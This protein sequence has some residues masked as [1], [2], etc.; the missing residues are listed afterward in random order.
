MQYEKI[1]VVTRK[2]RLDELIER[3]N[4]LNQA[5]FYIEHSGGNFK[6]Y[7]DEHNAYYRSLDHVHRSIDI[8]L[9]FQFMDRYLLST[10][11]IT[12]KDVVVSVGQD[13]LAANTAKYIGSQPL[14]AI[15]PDPS[16]IDGILC[17]I[18]I[19]NWHNVLLR[20]LNNKSKIKK[21]TLAKI[22]LNDTQSLIAFNDFFIGVKSHVSSRYTIEFGD[23]KERQSSSGIIVSTGAGSTGWLSSVFNMGAAISK[24]GDGHIENKLKFAW[25]EKRLI[26][27]VR[28][29]FLSRYSSI[30]L[31]AGLIDEKSSLKIE[32]H[33]AINGVIF[34]DGLEN[35]F[36]EFNAGSMAT[37]SVAD[38]RAHLVL[39]E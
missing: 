38:Q 10:A 14:I 9:K 36:L 28:E 16:R 34:S 35:D 15:N 7:Q 19:E 11:T 1:V 20:T 27:I 4:T 22:S 30:K 32:S 17:K 31:T 25:D 3:F 8:G 26:F 37:V 33:N 13:G 39:A 5:K 2:T 24:F 29:P 6:E 21:V 12:N 18:T 23:M